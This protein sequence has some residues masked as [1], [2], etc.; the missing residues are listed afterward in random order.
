M[1]V[2][3]VVRFTLPAMIALRGICTMSEV[4]L[5]APVPATHTSVP[6]LMTP[7]ETTGMTKGDPGIWLPVAASSTHISDVVPADV[8]LVM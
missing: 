8:S 4:P 7:C 6:S 1:T 3:F 5:P 2:S